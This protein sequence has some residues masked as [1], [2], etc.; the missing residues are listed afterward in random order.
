MVYV[1][2]F[3]LIVWAFGPRSP[4]DFSRKVSTAGCEG[5]VSSRSFSY[6]VCFTMSNNERHFKYYEY[7]PREAFEKCTNTTSTFQRFQ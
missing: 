1:E 3:S 7:I 2:V 5:S 4:C 6:R